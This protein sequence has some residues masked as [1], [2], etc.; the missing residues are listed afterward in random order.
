MIDGLFVVD[1]PAGITSHDVVARLRRT[2]KQKRIGHS[3]TLD[4]NATG[5]L[6][7]AVGRATR[8]L[9]FASDLPKS[10]ECEIVL[11]QATST[12]DADGEVTETWDMSSVTDDDIATAATKFKGDIMQVPPMVSAIRVNGKR[13]HQLAREGVEV[14]RKARPV[15]IYEIETEGKT[16]R[17]TCSSGTYVRTLVADIGE[18]LGGG[19]HLRNLV[20]TAI[21]PFD[22]GC[23]VPLASIEQDWQ[24]HLRPTGDLLSHLDQ[25]AVDESQAASVRH[26]RPLHLEA[27]GAGPWRVVDGER[28]LLAVYER[29][30]SG[31]IAAGV[32][33]DAV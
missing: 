2:I 23:A 6:L 24:P 18:S 13:L 10:Y 11:G 19:A 16:L 21:G 30:E 7:V 27:E 20:R 26:G 9:R 8:L 14:K 33:L 15:T 32:V 22:T 29:N 12:L 3:G 28:N 1:K 25:I 17:A 5:V 4:P 31:K